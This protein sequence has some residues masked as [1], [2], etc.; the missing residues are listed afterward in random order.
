MSQKGP[1]VKLKI[2]IHREGKKGKEK[3]ERRRAKK[4]GRNAGTRME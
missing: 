1:N 2:V 3:K 4:E